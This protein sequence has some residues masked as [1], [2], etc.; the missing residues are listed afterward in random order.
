M[1]LRRLARMKASMASRL[2]SCSRSSCASTGSPGRILSP[3]GGMTKS[4]RNDGLHAIER[5]VDRGG[6]FDRVLEKLQSNP[7]AGEARQGEAVNAVIENLL[8]AG[9]RQ[10]RHHHVDEC[11][12]RLM[13]GGRGFRRMVVAHQR[14]HAAV[15]RRAR[16]IDMAQ[17]VAAAVD[18]G[19]L[20]V[21][22]GKYAV[23]IC[24]RRAFPPAARPRRRWPRDP[25]SGPA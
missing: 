8:H 20:A 4:R 9:R 2:L 19:S 11:E 18:A 25:R 16:E 12:I 10:D 3:P 6:G 22:N 15:A 7:D 17:R 24:L 1:R 14:E 5:A 23:D 13:R 21:P